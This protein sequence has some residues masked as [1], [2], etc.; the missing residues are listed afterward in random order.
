MHIPITSAES[1]LQKAGTQFKTLYTHGSLSVEIYKPDQI[2]QQ[3]PHDRDEVY[4][5]VAGNG[6]FK[7][8]DEYFDIGPNDFLFV[9]TGVEHRFIDFTEDFSTWV[10]FY[11]PAGGEAKVD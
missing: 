2:D 5:V 11:G 4:I 7:K 3:Q 9:P 6:K 1:Q 8:G 10:I